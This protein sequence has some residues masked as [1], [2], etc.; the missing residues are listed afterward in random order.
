[1][2]GKTLTPNEY[3]F[4]RWMADKHPRLLA[5]AENQVKQRG[6]LSGI[7]DSIQN[8]LN[9]VSAGL[10]TYTQT[11]AQAKLVKTNVQRAAQ[12]L[13]PVTESG[14]LYTVPDSDFQTRKMPGGIPVWGWIAL[15]V[16]ALFLLRE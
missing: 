1:M 14:Q 9:S 13:P 2:E 7:T 3:L 11:K 10:Q 5:A 8:I 12:G 16:G 4:I 15:G 6:A